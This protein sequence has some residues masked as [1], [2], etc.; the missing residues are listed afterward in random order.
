MDGSSSTILPVL[1]LSFPHG[2]VTPQGVTHPRTT[3][4]QTCLTSEFRWNLKPVSFQKIS[5]YME[6]HHSFSVGRCGM[7]QSTPLGARRPRRHTRT[8]R[9]SGS[10]TILSHPRLQ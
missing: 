8:T 4:A 10:D 6:A 3:L 1:G 9:Q 2:F 7:S 5:F